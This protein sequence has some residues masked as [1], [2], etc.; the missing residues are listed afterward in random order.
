MTTRLTDRDIDE[1]ARRIAADIRGGALPMPQFVPSPANAPVQAGLGV[2][3][4]VDEAV[5]AARAAQPQFVTL[6][7]EH[8]ARII[9]AIRKAMLENAEVLAKAAHDETGYGRYEDKVVKN[10]LV[11]ERTPGI[12]ELYPG[13]VTGDH[14]LTLTE[15]APFGTIAA[16]TPTTNPTSTIICN[17]IHTPRTAA[18]RRSC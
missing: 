16:I 2:F 17:T 8:R 3:Q 18:C 15:P 4:T 10:R 5:A 14:G 7:L 12:E 11:T 1:I 9:A 13:V 6:K